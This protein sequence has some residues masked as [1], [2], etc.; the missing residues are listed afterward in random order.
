MFDLNTTE[1]DLHPDDVELFRE[2]SWFVFGQGHTEYDRQRVA[3]YDRDIAHLEQ[4]RARVMKRFA[5]YDR[6]IDPAYKLK[7][8]WFI[9]HESWKRCQFEINSLRTVSVK[10][11]LNSYELMSGKIEGVQLKYY[12]SDAAVYVYTWLLDAI[13]ILRGFDGDHAIGSRVVKCLI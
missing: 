11:N 1:M 10:L 5:T 2:D 12:V 13:V 7:A 9:Y 3:E 6:L 8:V 4:K